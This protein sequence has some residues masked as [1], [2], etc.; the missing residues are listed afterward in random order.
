M[1]KRL[2]IGI[3]DRAIVIDDWFVIDD[4][5]RCSAS[6]E[7]CVS[8]ITERDSEGFKRFTTAVIRQSDSD[9]S[10]GRASLY[11][12]V[13]EVAVKSLL[14]AE[15]VEVEYVTETSLAA[16]WLKDTATFAVPA[17]SLAIRSST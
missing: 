13:P 11:R 16:A 7:S 14:D 17:P 6:R 15:S 3:G 10:S 1:I 8:G 9:H 4:P 2:R 12:W 5:D